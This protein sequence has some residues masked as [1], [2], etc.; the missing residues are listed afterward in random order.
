MSTQESLISEEEMQYLTVA[1]VIKEIE[2][3]LCFLTNLAIEKR[4]KGI[5]TSIIEGGISALSSMLYLISHNA[6]VNK[7]MAALNEK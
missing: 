6:K 5:D 3:S 1:E 4:I 7:S 2:T